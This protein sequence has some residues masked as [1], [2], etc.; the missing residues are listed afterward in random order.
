[1]NL[2][3]LFN[4]NLEK[5]FNRI[6]VINQ[7]VYGDS[8]NIIKPPVNYN[9]IEN[10]HHQSDE[11]ITVADIGN[12]KIAVFIARL[13]ASKKIEII[14][15]GESKTEGIKKGIIANYSKV[16]Q[17]L[18]NAIDKA[19]KQADFIPKSI[20]A[21]ISCAVKAYEHQEICVR[22]RHSEIISDDI[23]K[24]KLAIH[25]SRLYANEYI[26]YT[27]SM[28]FNVDGV[29]EIINPI[30]MNGTSIEGIFKVLT[31]PS[32]CIKN[33]RR[34]CDLIGISL[35]T[36]YPSIITSAESILNREEKAEGVIV[37][38]IGAEKSDIAIYKNSSL[39]FTER[40]PYGGN[41]ITKDIAK[42]TGLFLKN[43]EE[44]KIKHGNAIYL[45]IDDNET[46]EAK[47]FKHYKK[48]VF[49]KDLAF[50]IQCR[51]IE[52]LELINFIISSHIDKHQII[53]GIVFTGGPSNTPQFKKLL[54][55]IFKTNY[56]YD[57]KI[58][59]IF[60]TI[61][62]EIKKLLNQPTYTSALG[63]LELEFKKH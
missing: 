49:K 20:C 7:R 29:D 53:Y 16:S 55:P 38:D 15:F 41:M 35:K 45:N 22:K 6:S 14:G 2:K 11:I 33:L 4:F 43:A 1:M 48:A 54:K 44:I 60:T 42:Y 51:L 25:Q 5:I 24:L 36:T 26:L 23:E 9:T 27:E 37:V 30:G 40:I 57:F 46:I 31:C 63:I 12:Y 28:H 17:C 34:C 13:N 59:P 47:L 52:I 18:K 21:S 8:I 58:K 62:P 56:F 50:V 19:A 32:V 39:F 61:N 10:E 3:A